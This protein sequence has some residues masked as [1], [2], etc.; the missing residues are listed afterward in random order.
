VLQY[1]RVADTGSALSV[2]LGQ[3]PAWKRWGLYLIALVLLA[4]VAAAAFFGAAF[5]RE[6]LSGAPAELQEAPR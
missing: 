1:H 4:G 6:K 5:L 3:L 2:E